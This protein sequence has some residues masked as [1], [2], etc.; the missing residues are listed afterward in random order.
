MKDMPARTVLIPVHLRLVP[1][2]EL[3]Q[4]NAALINGHVHESKLQLYA[5]VFCYATA[6]EGNIA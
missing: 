6:L 2:L 4:A 1:F 5:A 3:R